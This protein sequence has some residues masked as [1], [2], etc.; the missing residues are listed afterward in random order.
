MSGFREPRYFDRLSNAVAWRRLLFVLLAMAASF[1][2]G[3]HYGR[4]IPSTLF[5]RPVETIRLMNDYPIGLDVY[6][7]NSR[8]AREH[9]MQ[10]GWGDEPAVVV[11]YEAVTFKEKELM[12]CDVRTHRGAGLTFAVNPKWIAPSNPVASK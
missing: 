1:A 9:F 10:F 8:D 5:S 6:P 12:L 2:A 11:G 4:M 3:I 7:L